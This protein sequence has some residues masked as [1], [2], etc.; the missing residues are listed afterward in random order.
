MRAVRSGRTRR[1]FGEW[2][3][4]S[5]YH[6]NLRQLHPFLGQVVPS[7]RE[8]LPINAPVAMDW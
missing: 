8:N 4:G 5:D 7:E 1:P 2:S 6:R 3:V